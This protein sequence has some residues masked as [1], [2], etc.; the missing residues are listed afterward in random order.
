MKMWSVYS[1]CFLSNVAMC[2][3]WQ[4]SAIRSRMI[5]QSAGWE[6]SAIESRMIR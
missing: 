6:N 4:N 5:R 1:I 2:S 3:D